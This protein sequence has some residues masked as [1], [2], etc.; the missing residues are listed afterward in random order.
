MAKKIKKEKQLNPIISKTGKKIDDKG[1]KEM[2]LIAERIESLKK[3]YSGNDDDINSFFV[4]VINKLFDTKDISLKTEYLNVGENFAGTRLEFYSKYA[5]MPYLAN[6]I[7]IF[8]KKRVS[9]ERKGRKEIVMSLKDR[10]QEIQR[11]QALKMGG[12]FGY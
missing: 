6:F 10:E 9:L 3:E 8:E 12:Q 7:E 4:A 1:K 2:L 11:Q 5:N